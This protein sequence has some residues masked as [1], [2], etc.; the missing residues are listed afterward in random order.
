MLRLCC[1]SHTLPSGA[2]IAHTAD[3]CAVVQIFG[4]VYVPHAIAI[5]DSEPFAQLVGQAAVRFPILCCFDDAKCSITSLLCC[6]T[7]AQETY[8]RKKINMLP[9]Q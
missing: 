5:T 3:R 6:Y 4:V 7:P 1:T 9:N 8:I 2:A